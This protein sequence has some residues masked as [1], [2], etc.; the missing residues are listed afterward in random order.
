MNKKYL[1]ETLSYISD[2]MDKESDSREAMEIAI[3]LVE[4][5]YEQPHVE[6]HIVPWEPTILYDEGDKVLFKGVQCIIGQE[7][8]GEEPNID[9]KFCL[10]CSQFNEKDSS[11]G[12]FMECHTLGYVEFKLNMDEE[13]FVCGF[14]K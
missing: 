12:V 10:N 2:S 1:K 8:A 13:R 9:R 3:S 7:C 11:R 5:H 6:E 14:Y 4:T